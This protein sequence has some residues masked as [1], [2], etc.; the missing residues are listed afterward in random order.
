[1]NLLVL[2][3]LENIIKIPYDIFLSE[4]PIENHKSIHFKKEKQHKT[5]VL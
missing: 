3:H 2:Q 1:M 4:I 5:N